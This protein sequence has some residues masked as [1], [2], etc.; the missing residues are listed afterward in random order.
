MLRRHLLKSGLL[1]GTLATGFRPFGHGIA[2]TAEAAPAFAGLQMWLNT[3]TP[4]TVG[5]LRGKVVLINF[6]TYS[7]INCRRTVPYL[8]RLQAAYGANGLQVIGIHTPE[9]RFERV[10]PNVEAAVQT[11]GIQYPI[12][13][14]NDFQ[15][16]EKWKNRAWPTFYII[17]R[18]GR[19]V[20]TREGEGHA[21]EI[22]GVIRHLLDIDNGGRAVRASDDPDLSRIGTAEIYFGS[23]HRTPQDPAQSPRAGEAAYAFTQTQR[24]RINQYILDG[25]WVREPEPL[26]LRSSH[27]GLRLRFSAA[28]LHL[29]AS[30][31]QPATMII[32]I[33]E[34]EARTIEVNRPTLY[35]LFDG[36]AYTE[37]LL[38][39]VA[40]QPGLSLFSA[41]FG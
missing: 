39:L 19:I 41:T 25:V 28:K 31:P 5:G 9:F 3:Q 24:P 7:C 12:G 40:N 8:N 34:G 4:L 2:Q 23:Q 6:W 37:H 33:D 20:L 22:E 18:E 35:T 38:D 26:V 16:W 36:D 10:R 13:Q 1:A 32:T 30:A 27:G 14:D 21:E 17:D 29:V 15:T 11:L